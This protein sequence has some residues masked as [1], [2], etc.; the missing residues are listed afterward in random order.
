VKIYPGSKID[1]CHDLEIANSE[2]GI[3]VIDDNEL[4]H[5]KV[6]R[7]INRADKHK[8]LVLINELRVSNVVQIANLGI[9]NIISYY[10]IAKDFSSCISK[11]KKGENFFSEDIKSLLLDSL[12]K[13]SLVSSTLTKKE[14]EIIALLGQG[15]S[16]AEVGSALNIS[17]LTVNVHR[18]NI[19]RKLNISNNSHFI[20]YCSDSIAK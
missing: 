5:E 19:K 1:C 8:I 13:N 10:S 14:D 11:I 9:K 3:F 7:F 6:L 4:S 18:S 20:K 2:S 12:G 16:A 17:N 15:L